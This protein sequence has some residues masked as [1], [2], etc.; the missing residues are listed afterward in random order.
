[1]QLRT[2]LFISTFVF[3]PLLA[4]C[5]QAPNP[6]ATQTVTVTPG[7]S[8]S[9]S[10]SGPSG[11][12]T[13]S[14]SATPRPSQ[15][16]KPTLG[17][18]C[19]SLL[20]A[21]NI[22]LAV[23]QPLVGRTSFV[24]GLPDP[25]IERLAY[26]NCRYGVAAPARGKPAVAKVEIGL[27]LYASDIRAQTRVQGTID[28]FTGL[29]A[30]QAQVR[31]DKYLATILT[32]YQRPTLVVA[33]GPRTVAITVDPKLFGSARTKVMVALAKEALDAT[34][35]YVAGGTVG[36]EPTPSASGTL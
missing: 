36:P 14:H 33:A 13:P 32:G 2:R 8:G 1:M 10:S 5:T 7:P 27:S 31:V 6:D 3:V 23:G 4:G 9:S 26:L 24:V 18:T 28:D 25:K 30:K 35:N 22:N 29:G 34:A 21:T 17:G 19:D 11:S 12:S 20:P 16:A 15:T